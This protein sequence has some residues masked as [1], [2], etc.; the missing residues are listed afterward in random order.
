MARIGRHV[1]V[2][3]SPLQRSRDL[4]CLVAGQLLSTLGAELTMVA[5]AYQVYEL[6]RSPLAVGLVSLAQVLPLIAG[7]LLGGS[8]ADAADRRLVLVFSQ[9]LMAVCVAGL[10]VNA[11][12]GPV[13][14][15]LFV[16]PALTS[17]FSAAAESGMSAILPNLVLNDAATT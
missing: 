1:L 14:W 2:D 17:G 11:A 16:L 12:S 10:A 8:L 9:L 6:T 4:R 3:V 15:P 7:A 13:L 5:V